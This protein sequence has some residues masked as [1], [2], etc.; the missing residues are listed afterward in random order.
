MYGA[1]TGVY[2]CTCME[3]EK[4]GRDRRTGGRRETQREG[5]ESK[6]EE[7][8]GRE[9]RGE[10]ERERERE[11]RKERGRGRETDVVRIM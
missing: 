8:R 5:C 4:F 9:R 1:S 3:I 6:R 10:R 2:I 7:R 11:R